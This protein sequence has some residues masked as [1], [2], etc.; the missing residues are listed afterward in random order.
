MRCVPLISKCLGTDEQ[1]GKGVTVWEQRVVVWPGVG[2]KK[3]ICAKASVVEVFELSVKIQ[4]S[5]GQGWE[6]LLRGR[7]WKSWQEHRS[8]WVF[9]TGISFG[10]SG[11][12]LLGLRVPTVH[13]KFL[14]IQTVPGLCR[15]RIRFRHVVVLSTFPPN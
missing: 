12:A 1:G 13:E 15:L 6:K 9:V 7:I 14:G 11:S 2:E 10:I 5:L 4:P 3:C 8:C